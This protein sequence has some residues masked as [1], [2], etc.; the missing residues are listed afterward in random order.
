[1]LGV[2][3]P[4]TVVEPI[5]QEFRPSAV[6][7]LFSLD[8]S[9]WHRFAV[10][11]DVTPWKGIALGLVCAGALSLVIPATSYWFIA[12]WL[13]PLCLFP[14]LQVHRRRTYL[15]AS[16]LVF[17]SGILRSSIRAVPLH[18]I[19]S[20]DVSYPRFGSAVDVGDIDV[21]IPGDRI[22]MFGLR[23]PTR[24]AQL[25]LDAREAGAGSAVS[26]T[27]A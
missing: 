1:M 8:F 15:T 11:L 27:S 13:V 18:T 16:A 23:N 7:F 6:A 22:L 21:N 2:V 24:L 10:A 25:I 14:V 9:G 20:V 5:L 19:Q 4:T 26:Q 3:A 12:A 17:V